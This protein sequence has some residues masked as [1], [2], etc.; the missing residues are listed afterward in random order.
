MMLDYYTHKDNYFTLL[1]TILICFA[2]GFALA[3]ISQISKILEWVFIIITAGF[4]YYNGGYL[5][6]NGAF[7]SLIWKIALIFTGAILLSIEL[8]LSKHLSWYNNP[9]SFTY[10]YILFLGLIF[11]KDEKVDEHKNIT[12]YTP[13]RFKNKSIRIE[14][15]LD[16]ISVMVACY[17]VELCKPSYNRFFRSFKDLLIVIGVLDAYS[18][19]FDYKNISV[20][21]I[22]EI[23]NSNNYKEDSLLEFTLA[24]GTLI[25][26]AEAPYIPPEDI[27]QMWI[28]EKLKVRNNIINAINKD[29]DYI[30]FKS[31]AKQK[32]EDF[33]SRLTTDDILSRIQHVELIKILKPKSNP[34][35]SLIQ[36][37]IEFKEYFKRF[38]NKNILVEYTGTIDYK[39]VQNI[40]DSINSKL[41]DTNEKENIIRRVYPIALELISNL[42]YFSEYPPIEF[43]FKIPTKI[44]VFSLKSTK[45]EYIITTGNFV[46][47]QWSE[48]LAQRIEGINSFSKEDLNSYLKL[49]QN[50]PMNRS[51]GNDANG[52]IEA[53]LMTDSNYSFRIYQFIPCY[54][55]VES[56]LSFNKTTL[57]N[58]NEEKTHPL[59]KHLNANL[60]EKINILSRFPGVFFTSKTK[61]IDRGK[62]RIDYLDE[63]KKEAER[64]KKS[65]LI[66]RIDEI[67]EKLH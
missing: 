57:L 10:F 62:E 23:A 55:W 63:L 46:E 43:S 1:S 16:V 60:E 4:F 44:A 32:T 11:K 48:F 26:I 8:F 12:S 39:V 14:D 36:P 17:F 67:K 40:L 15:N 7:K 53:K 18:Y 35:K 42:Y 47:T 28:S 6:S 9:W 33:F 61:W 19:I 66:S 38:I 50:N 20:D 29:G 59:Y 13:N 64:N 25:F 45:N 31:I 49:A 37:N 22:V 24:L 58:E 27:N 30:K 2:F 34:S 3:G 54:S 21:Q 5:K 52:L 56:S 41:I 65:E 51:R